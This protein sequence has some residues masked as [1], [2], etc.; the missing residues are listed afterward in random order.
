MVTKRP[1]NLRLTEMI[2]TLQ[3]IAGDSNHWSHH[4]Y[5]SSAVKRGITILVCSEM[6]VDI[7]LYGPAHTSKKAL[8]A[9][10]VPRAEMSN[11]Q[12]II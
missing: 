9:T 1:P 10:G 2:T 3:I 6:T 4:I 11:F 7:Y 12:V 8:W 5:R